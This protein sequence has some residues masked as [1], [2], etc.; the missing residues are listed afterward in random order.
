MKKI[1]LILLII[2][3]SHL[4][5]AQLYDANWVFGDSIGLSFQNPDSPSVFLTPNC[6]TG[7]NYSSMSDAEGNLL[8][9]LGGPSFVCRIDTFICFTLQYSVKRVILW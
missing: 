1:T 2:G 5:H 8:F 4:I 3:S 7:E 6:Y 9:H